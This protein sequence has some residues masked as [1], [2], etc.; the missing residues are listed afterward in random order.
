MPQNPIDS[1]QLADLMK[2]HAGSLCQLAARWA[3]FPEDCVQ[4][5]FISLASSIPAPNNPTAWLYLVTKRK[6]INQCRE[7]GRRKKREQRKADQSDQELLT[8]EQIVSGQD[9]SDKLVRLV[10]NLPEPQ[11]EI[12]ILRTWGQLGWREIHEQ[13]KIPPTTVQRHYKSALNW[14]KEKM[15]STWVDQKN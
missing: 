5:A 11:R 6:A 13:T 14:L 7:A 4:E 8:P 2:N 12:V 15:E 3:E 10:Q 1:I 9:E